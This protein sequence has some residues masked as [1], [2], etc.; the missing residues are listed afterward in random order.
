[1]KKSK[2]D[3]TQGSI[4]KNLIHLA[5]P[6]ALSNILQDSFSVV[7]MIFVGKLGAEAI[8]AVDMSSNLQRL[9]SVLSLGISMGTVVLVS[10]SIGAQQREQGENIA[11]QAL[12]L[13]VVCPLGIACIGFPL[14][15]IGLRLLGAEEEVVRLGVPYLR[16]TLLGGVMMFVSMTLGSIFRAGGDSMTPMVVM[17]FSTVL[18]IVLDPLLIFGLWKFPRL[19][20][21]GSAYASVIGRSAGVVIFLYLCFIGRSIISL[22]HVKRRIDLSAM[23]QI[24]RLGIFSS[25]QGFLRHASRL[26]F[27]RVVAIYGTNAVAAYAICM[28]LRILVMHL[29]F[30]F[31]NAVAP[32]VGQN[33]GAGQ[34]DRAEKSAN[35]AGG[36]ATVFMAVLGSL[37]FLFPHFCIR[38]FTGQTEVITVGSVYLRYLS[39]TFAFIAISIVFGRA[40]NGAG[41]T[42]SPMVMTFICQLGIGLLL[43][44]LLS[45]LVGIKGVWIGIA[46]SN[47]VQG[48]LMWLWFRRGTWKTKALVGKK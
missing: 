14:A 40:L 46:L 47:V 6:I 45:Y 28:R 31:A 18:N 39:A 1:M 29:G 42:V 41:D 17:I 25:M 2:H 4:F 34:I 13:S 37:L 35:L 20:V 36:L 23:G 7:D 43:V 21:A 19:G 12:I 48:V 3:L 32:M 30:G 16:I 44:I 26:G 9:I 33:I 27:I 24:L 8:S 11:M 22:K 15:E 38:V 5:W 10:Q